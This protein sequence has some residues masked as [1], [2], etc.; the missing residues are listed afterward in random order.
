MCVVLGFGGDIS[1]MMI[2]A[3]DAGGAGGDDGASIGDSGADGFDAEIERESREDE[4]IATFESNMT[5]LQTLGAP[6]LFG[7]FIK[8]AVFSNFH[9]H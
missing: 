6:S 5:Y 8:S 3:G 2:G 4:S 1:E 7:F 9:R